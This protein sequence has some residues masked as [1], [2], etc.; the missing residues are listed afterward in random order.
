MPITSRPVQYFG[1]QFTT[2]K[3]VASLLDFFSNRIFIERYDED[4]NVYR[5][6]KPPIHFANR[7][8]FTTIIKAANQNNN[9]VSGYSIDLKRILPRMALNIVSMT[10]D[11]ERKIIKSHKVKSKEYD[12]SGSLDS[13]LSPVPYILDLELAII[14]KT[15][16]DTWQ[17]IEQIVPYFTPS[18]CLD[19]KIL[20]GFDSESISFSISTV[21]PDAT[22]ELGIMDERVFVSTISFMTRINYYYIKRNTKIIKEIIANYYVGKDETYKKIKSYSLSAQNLVPVTTVAGRGDEPCDIEIDDF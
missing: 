11:A 13:V 7:E 4:G 21:S 3:V 22:E 17:I 1:H 2:R 14:T 8:R 16:D 5:Y 6:I 12:E 20:E 10:Y 15:I 9:Q 19:L 18:L